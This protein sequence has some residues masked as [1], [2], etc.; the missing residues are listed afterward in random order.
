MSE[1]TIC[2]F[3]KRNLK[4]KISNDL[5]VITAEYFDDQIYI[6]T[7]VF[8]LYMWWTREFLLLL[9]NKKKTYKILLA[10]HIQ[11]NV[12]VLKFAIFIGSEEPC[13]KLGRYLYIEREMDIRIN[14]CSISVSQFTM[15]FLRLH[16]S[17]KLRFNI[18][19]MHRKFHNS[20]LFPSCFNQELFS[21]PLNSFGFE[22][23]IYSLSTTI[24]KKINFK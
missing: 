9:L 7:S 22:T 17:A 14:T 8:L 19:R 16:W 21:T 13:S 12:K 15:L 23:L 3:S 24:T 10:C 5:E 11:Q 6:W 18:V 20:W 2:P 4:R 1:L